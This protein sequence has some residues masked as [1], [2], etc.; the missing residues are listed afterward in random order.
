MTQ[1]PKVTSYTIQTMERSLVE[2]SS[3]MKK[4]EIGVFKKTNMRL[5]LYMKKKK[6]NK[7]KLIR[8]CYSTFITIS[9]NS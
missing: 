8:D 1:A 9:I 5:F 4:Y 6:T 7:G 3:L 2:M